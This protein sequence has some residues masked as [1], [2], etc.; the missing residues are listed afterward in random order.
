MAPHDNFMAVIRGTSGTGKGTRV[1]QVLE[2]LKTKFEHHPVMFEFEGKTKQYGIAFPDLTVIFV[3]TITTSNKS[4][5]SS[6][7][8]MDYIHSTVKKAENARP[9]AKGFLEQ[10]YSLVLEGEPMM[11]SDKFRPLFMYE[12]YGVSRYLMPHYWYQN[13][14]QYDERIMGRSGKLAGDSGWSRNESYR[15]EYERTLEE[16]DTLGLDTSGCT[17]D[18]HDAPLEQ[19]GASLL[20]YM[21]QAALIGDFV[22]FTHA[23]PMLRSIDGGNPLATTKNVFDIF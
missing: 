15:R 23:H 18:P 12:Y 4:G 3:G 9:I 10:G 21:D 5:L 13:R 11:Q 19:L 7:S 14:E 8:S 16:L 17:L 22:E 6:W 20:V 2:F 1:C